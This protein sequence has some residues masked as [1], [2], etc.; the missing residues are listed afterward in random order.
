MDYRGLFSRNRDPDAR[1]VERNRGDISHLLFVTARPGIQLLWTVLVAATLLFNLLRSGPKHPWMV[2]VM[3][4]SWAAVVIGNHFFPFDEYR[5]VLFFFLMSAFLVLTASI[6]Y[7]TGGR[8]SLLGFLFFA[9]PILSSAYYGYPGTLIMS[10]LTAV[11]RYIPFMSGNVTGV[12]HL[13]LAL[14]ALAYV[15]IGMMS[16]YVVEGE[17]MYARESSEYRH[18]LELARHRERDVSRIYNLSRRFSYTLDLDTIL[19]T[20]AALARQMLACE[21]ALVFLVEDGRPTLKAS[22]GI[23]PFCDMASVE[24][25]AGETWVARLESGDTSVRQRASLDWLPL[26]PESSSKHHNLAAV[27]LFIGGEVAGCLI[28]FSALS[29]P[30][31]ETHVEMLSTIA[32]Q[33]AVAVEKARLYTRTLE[34]KAKVETILGALRDGLVLADAQG[35]LVDANPVAERM[36]SLDGASDAKLSDVLSSVVT[37]CDLGHLNISEAVEAVL[38]GRVVFGEMTMA[39][40]SRMTVQSHFIPLRDQVGR[41][42][43]AVLFLHDITELKRVDEMKSN[44]VSNVSHELR[45]PLTSI[46]GFVSLLLAGRAGPLSTNQRRYLD[47]VKEQSSYLTSLI[48]DLLDLSRLQAKRIKADECMLSVRE[49]TEAAVSDLS[50]PARD[51]DVEVRITLRDDLPAV[52]A[53]PA[54]LTQVLTNIISNAIKFTPAGGLVEVTA[55]ANGPVVQVQV[56][57]TGLGISPSALPHIFDRFFQAH[58]VEATDGSGFGLGLAITRE[59]VELHGGRIWAESEP[60]RGSSFFFTVPVFYE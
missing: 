26:P 19:K 52:S 42:S 5:P 20:T 2:G 43:G 12:E 8:N 55:H 25:P 36:L 34:D 44:F 28:C 53:D 4:V 24:L 23:L 50:R 27:P 57:D 13:S 16:C 3:V 33:A 9:I 35:L 7:L 41:V 18:L 56:S 11:V 58:P 38:D 49:M 6:V 45:T 46:S 14:T 21:G 1:R 32:S 60:G 29:R 48:E 22:L 47:V 37:D 17:K 54:R 40:D 30:F 10:V 59:I 39:S 15:F 31:R 51:G